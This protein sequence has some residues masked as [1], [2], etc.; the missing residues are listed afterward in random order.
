M[1]VM[2]L[3]INAFEQKHFS[4]Q[5]KALK[6]TLGSQE[7]LGTAKEQGGKTQV[8]ANKCQGILWSLCA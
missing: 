8:L 6:T 1:R 4:C 5:P 3:K 2:H 7:E